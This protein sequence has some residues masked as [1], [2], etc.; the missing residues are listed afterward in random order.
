MIWGVTMSL[1]LMLELPSGLGLVALI[2]LPLLVIGGLIF[3][4][5]RMRKH[6]PERKDEG[7]FRR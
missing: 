7:E 1:S 3:Y 6:T 5:H 4:V 2:L